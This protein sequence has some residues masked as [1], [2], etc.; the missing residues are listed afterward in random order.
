MFH[1]CSRPSEANTPIA[2]LL[3]A[4]IGSTQEGGRILLHASGTPESALIVVSDNGPGIDAD[5]AR[6]VRLTVE[7][8][9]GVF[10]QMAEA[11]QGTATKI[12]LP[13]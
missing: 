9:G 5:E 2:S 4:A 3:S 11:G 10:T 1:K 12:E 6:E 8:H 7:A 13:R